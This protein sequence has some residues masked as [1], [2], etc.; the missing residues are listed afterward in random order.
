VRVCRRT[1]VDRLAAAAHGS[2]LE[3]NR[4]CDCAGSASE[5]IA[6]KQLA[7]FDAKSAPAHIKAEAVPPHKIQLAPDRQ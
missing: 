4:S 1:R 3:H 5:E 2:R 7:D 6:E